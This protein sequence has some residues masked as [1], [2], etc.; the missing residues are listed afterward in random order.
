MNAESD[1]RKSKPVKA[2]SAARARS[3]KSTDPG[4][5]SAGDASPGSSNGTSRTPERAAGGPGVNELIQERA[6][7]LYLSSGCQ[8]GHALEHWLE[9][10]RQIMVSL[11]SEPD[12]SSEGTGKASRS[13]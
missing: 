1:K 13:R 4:P 7:R 12:Q 8:Q 9:A 3:R 5:P 2:A 10:E 11:Q 6:Y